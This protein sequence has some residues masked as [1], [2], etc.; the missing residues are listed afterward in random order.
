MPHVIDQIASD[1]EPK[2]IRDMICL[3]QISESVVVYL[4]TEFLLGPNSTKSKHASRDV[5]Q[6]WTDLY[7]P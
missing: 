7:R 3:I 6:I 5:Q 4:S 2:L 1:D